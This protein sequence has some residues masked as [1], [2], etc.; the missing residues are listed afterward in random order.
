MPAPY[1]YKLHLAARRLI[2]QNCNLLFV[3]DSLSVS[4]GPGY[5]WFDSVFT[6]FDV[7]LRGYVC[8]RA[9]GSSNTRH[10]LMNFVTTLGN[11][12]EIGGTSLGGHTV[13]SGPAFQYGLL[14]RR[15]SSNTASAENIARVLMRGLG[16]ESLRDI[17]PC[18]GTR[19]LPVKFKFGQWVP[20]TSLSGTYGF[21]R[22][23]GLSS[24]AAMPSLVP[25]DGVWRITEF[26]GVPTL[27][28]A[29]SDSEHRITLDTAQDET[30]RSLNIWGWAVE[31][32]NVV[33]LSI[34]FIAGG[35]WT[36]VNHLPPSY[37]QTT[38][39]DN[40]RRFTD[41]QLE[42]YFKLGGWPDVIW[43]Q[44]GANRQADEHDFVGG[45]HAQFVTRIREVIAR[46]TDAV[47]N[48]GRP[49]PIIILV[50]TWELVNG[51]AMSTVADSFYTIAQDAE[52]VCFLNLYQLVRDNYGAV[53]SWSAT[54]LSDNVHQNEA[55][56]KMFG[57][58]AWQEIT[59][60]AAAVIPPE[61]EV[62]QTVRLTSTATGTHYAVAYNASGQVW[63]GVAWATYSDGDWLTYGLGAVAAGNRYTTVVPEDANRVE[64]YLQLG[65][66]PDADD[67][68]QD[69]W[70]VVQADNRDGDAI[71]ATAAILTA[72]GTDGD[73]D[74]QLDGIA[75]RVLTALPDAAPGTAGG[76]A[77]V[78]DVDVT[79]NVPAPQ[80]TPVLVAAPVVSQITSGE[81]VTVGPARP[82]NYR[83]FQN[84]AIALPINPVDAE[85]D[86][87]DLT[88]KT[89]RFVVHDANGVVKF[90]REAADG[91][92]WTDGTVTVPITAANLATAA[93]WRWKLWSVTDEMT[94]GYGRFLIEL[95]PFEAPTP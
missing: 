31:V 50:A 27:N 21:Y 70:S 84:N 11:S 22:S 91:V 18:Q 19:R 36:T 16:E 76:L 34:D 89:L 25:G 5:R 87:I 47:V 52:N 40:T 35:G 17:E 67:P 83:V 77:R 41:A 56:T 37:G 68:L 14:Q 8:P 85:G 95:S 55:G 64:L 72:L 4:L 53:A 3:G 1:S 80:V 61:V 26:T 30:G 86:A 42:E 39:Y 20:E 81:L 51:P 66:A 29:P 38:L 54:Y 2:G 43:L 82:V 44:L 12:V 46:Y 13:P 78:Q 73:L 23:G 33:G 71:P 60:S 75:N 49:A 28:D 58:L 57:R 32:Q 6:S 15:F 69:V 65:V 94:L 9:S 10:N 24:S 45:G 63:N 90:T 59:A 74:E 93:D 62:D 88:G 79:V 7:P 48:S 92:V